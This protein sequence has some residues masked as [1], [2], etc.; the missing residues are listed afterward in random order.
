VEF[1]RSVSMEQLEEAQQLMRQVRCLFDYRNKESECSPLG[2]VLAALESKRQAYQ[3]SPSV[4]WA[5]GGDW[6]NASILL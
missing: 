5:L 4:T 1:L 3:D 2:G 6:R